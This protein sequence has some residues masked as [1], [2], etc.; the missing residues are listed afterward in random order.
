MGFYGEEIM[1]ILKPVLPYY[2]FIVLVSIY[3][4]GLDLTYLIMTLLLGIP[5]A[6]VLGMFVEY[7]L[8]DVLKPFNKWMDKE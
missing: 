8:E 5:L 6:Y 2:I 4:N 3:R 7:L 1:D